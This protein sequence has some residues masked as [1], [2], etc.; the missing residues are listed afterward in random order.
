M[1]CPFGVLMVE[2]ICGWEEDKKWRGVR[3]GG[4]RKVPVFI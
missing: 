1:F 4:V 2:I 3:W